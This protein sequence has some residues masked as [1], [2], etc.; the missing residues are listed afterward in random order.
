MWWHCP[1]GPN[2]TT[3]GFLPPPG[4]SLPKGRHYGS[5]ESYHSRPPILS[6][7]KLPPGSRL[8]G[9]CAKHAAVAAEKIEGHLAAREPKEAW[10]SIKGWYKAATNCVPKWAIYHL[11]PRLPMEFG[12][13]CCTS[14]SIS[15]T[16]QNWCAVPGVITGS[17]LMTRGVLLRV[18]HSPVSCL[19]CLLMP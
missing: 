8:K 15:E 16:Q 9:D 6:E 13:G 18:A 17:L 7:G 4:C 10:Q 12:Q 3:N 1:C 2:H 11:P 14:R 5:R 19:M